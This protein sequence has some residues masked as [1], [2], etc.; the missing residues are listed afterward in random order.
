MTK[1]FSFPGPDEGDEPDKSLAFKEPTPY[2]PLGLTAMTA[3]ELEAR[4]A[5]LEASMK[6]APEA[7]QS[8]GSESEPE[9][10]MTAKIAEWRAKS[11]Q[12]TKEIIEAEAEAEAQHRLYIRTRDVIL[13]L[14][15]NKR[16]EALVQQA[17]KLR[18]EAY[19]KLHALQRERETMDFL[20]ENETKRLEGKLTDA[21]FVPDLKP[22]KT[23]VAAAP[24]N[25]MQAMIEAERAA[26]EAR[27]RA[28]GIS[29]EEAEITAAVGAAGA[30]VIP[31]AVERH[32]PS[33]IDRRSEREQTPA[34][35]CLRAI[36]RY[37]ACGLTAWAD[38]IRDQLLPHLNTLTNEQLTMIAR[39]RA[40]GKIM[41]FMPSADLQLTHFDRAVAALKRSDSN[42]AIILWNQWTTWI[43]NRERLLVDGA[44]DHAHVSFVDGGRQPNVLTISKTVPRQREEL[45]QINSELGRQS[46]P[47]VDS[48]NPLEYLA[49][50]TEAD[51]QLDVS[52]YTRFIKLV[53]GGIVA[54]ADCPAGHVR[55]DCGDAGSPN[56]R[57][58]FR[59][60]RR[61]IF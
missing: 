13:A 8:V 48:A 58:G 43:Q 35:L 16:E 5:E 50:Q 32:T 3:A 14:P 20:V 22:G 4:V 54:D 6:T 28:H 29:N 19:K 56:S 49:L 10:D 42:D 25:S 59:L 47:A 44:P 34:E 15:A 12:L 24:K 52:T 45:A 30:T 31:P 40:N 55:L 26:V 57:S 11:E 27:N 38:Q 2:K 9:M 51:A 60:A 39:E 1:P 53:A 23:P 61:V 36:R 18:D 21:D 33:N 46:L 7:A 37:N 41:V 17:A